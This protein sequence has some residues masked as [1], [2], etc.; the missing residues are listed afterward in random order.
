MQDE[1]PVMVSACLAGLATRYD[2]GSTPHPKVLELIRAG[3]ALPVC[4]EQIG[5]L[6]TPRTCHELLD[7]R[8]IGKDGTDYTEAFESGAKQCLA[9]AELAGCKR[10]ILKSRSPS[11]G[12]GKIYD[13]SFSGKL[14]PGDGVLASLLKSAG[15]E[16]VSDQKL[17]D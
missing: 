1:A 15:I 8:V 3:K 16:V 17:D 6:P 9:L 11:C 14:I 12:S 13:G 4:P 7:G 10:A 5:G 2:G